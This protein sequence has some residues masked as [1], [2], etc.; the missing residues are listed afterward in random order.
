MA[1]IQS[2]TA[3][4]LWRK[5]DERAVI[6][7]IDL[8]LTPGEVTAL[9][10][11]SGAGKTTLLRLLAGM[12]R[13]DSGEVSSGD[14]T[15]SSTSKFV[16]IE[17]RNIGL[18]FQD[19]ALFPHLNVLQN[20]MFGLRHLPKPE[21]VA[22]AEGWI[23]KLGLT[24]RRDAYPHHLS[25][26]EQQ[27][28][29]IARALA[30]EP[31]AI[32]LDEPFS[33]LDPAMRDRVR[34]AALSAIR[35]AGIPALLVTH[36]ANEALVHADRIAVMGEGH[37]LQTGTPEEVYGA[38][39][40]FEGAAALGPIHSI[41]FETFQSLWKNITPP[42]AQILH[43]RPEAIQ[44]DPLSAV[45]AKV[46]ATRLAGPVTEL[47]LSVEGQNLFAACQPGHHAELGAEIG[48]SIR[49]DLIFSFQTTQT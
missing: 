38:P 6:K 25:G 48:I 23:T 7:G 14:V 24:K 39:I 15:L 20:V 35:A 41:P 27:R 12:E 17:K 43:Y 16:P 9:I 11:P 45:K 28:T 32:L 47:V 5:F 29:A 40:S 26:G 37:I 4:G 8:T 1:S 10:G 13:P 42:H 3:K 18:V 31:V 33:G 30:P 2:L 19:F 49:P 22:H 44:I 21:R 46:E 34:E 36:D